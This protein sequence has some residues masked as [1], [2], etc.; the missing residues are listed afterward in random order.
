LNINEFTVLTS[1]L[2]EDRINFSLFDSRNQKSY[3]Y[4]IRIINFD[5]LYEF[6]YEEI[7][8]VVVNINEI[9]ARVGGM[10]SENIKSGYV[11]NVTND[12]NILKVKILS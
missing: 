1:I 3:V 5:K 6:M 7:K 2:L 11:I 12:N 4:T 9:K 10:L 8:D